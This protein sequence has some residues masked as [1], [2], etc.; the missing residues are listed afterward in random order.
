MANGSFSLIK[1]GEVE[2]AAS[3]ETQDGNQMEAYLP[4]TVLFFMQTGQ[5]HIETGGQLHTIDRNNFGLLRKH[6]KCK[7]HKTWS[8]EEAGAKT[9]GFVLTNAYINRVVEKVSIPKSTR[10]T[11]TTFLSLQPTESLTTVMNFLIDH[12][13]NDEDI[14][15]VMVETK[16]E[17]ALK[18]LL[19]ANED[20]ASIFRE[21]SIAEIADL[22]K[23][24][25]H[26][27]LYNIPLKE[28]AI[29]SGRSLS[30]FNRDFRAI[31]NDTPHRWI[32]NKRLEY[33]R[34]L[35]FTDHKRP[36]EVFLASGFEDLS[37]FSR[38]FKKKFNITPS[39]FFSKLPAK[40]GVS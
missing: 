1:C 9:Y 30:S 36:S 15:P 29:R 37:H 3:C 5:L 20:A 33:A 2:I 13:D 25:D 22:E 32:M 35:M 4:S 23:L 27:F 38:S 40:E 6:T 34:Y 18:A 19:I 16:T 28:L 8:N 17:E 12:V 39:Q 31:Y 10:T 11:K 26:N 7:F 14:D 21:F 24:M